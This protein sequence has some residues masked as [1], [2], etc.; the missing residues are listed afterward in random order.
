M[1]SGCT[2]HGCP[3]LED[4]RSRPGLRVRWGKPIEVDSTGDDEGRADGR[5]PDEIRA[6][7]HR[8]RRGARRQPGAEPRTSCLPGGSRGCISATSQVARLADSS[9][10]QRG[11]R[12][13]GSS[14]V[15]RFC[16]GVR[17][18]ALSARVTLLDGL[19]PRRRGA[20]RCA[21]PCRRITSQEDEFAALAAFSPR[22][23]IARVEA[24][25]SGKPSIRQRAVAA[26]ARFLPA[27]GCSVLARRSLPPWPAPASLPEARPRGSISQF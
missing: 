27:S 6:P 7:L 1:G 2:A 24:L 9:R 22:K 26:R 10:C 16:L 20:T 3:M 25:A 4:A 8:G 5:A 13:A 12:R 21:R 11:Y 18:R 14:L 19:S 15:I 17:P 23:L